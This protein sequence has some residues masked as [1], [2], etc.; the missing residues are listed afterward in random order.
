MTSENSNVKLTIITVYLLGS[1]EPFR[2]TLNSIDSQSHAVFDHVIVVSGVSHEDDFRQRYE[3]QYRKLIINQDKSLYDAMNIGLAASEGDYVLFLNGGDEFMSCRSLE[4]VHELC[5]RKMCLL[6]RTAQY[7]QSDVYLRPSARRIEELARY[8]AHQGF[9]APL[10]VAKKYKYVDQVHSIGSDVKW[11]NNVMSDCKLIL[12]P[13]V[14]VKFSLGGV[15]NAPT[16][17]TCMRRYHEGGFYRFSLELLK[18]FL[19]KL[20]T[21]KWYYRLVYFFKYDYLPAG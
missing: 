15:S 18:L 19:F 10:S 8:P 1:E 7:Y 12:V 3:A 13:D 11:M 14:L 2:K 4:R 9:V 6:F 17:K 16:F 5:K 21:A 20:L